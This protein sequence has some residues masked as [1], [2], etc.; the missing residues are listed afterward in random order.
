MPGSNIPWVRLEK[1]GSVTIEVEV[2]DAAGRDIVLLHV[3]LTGTGDPPDSAGLAIDCL[4]PGN[5]VVTRVG[6]TFTIENATA[7]SGAFAEG[8]ALVSAIVALSPKPADSSQWG[9]TLR[10]KTGEKR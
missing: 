5:T 1:D 7:A 8:M 10:L 3:W 6:D 2:K 9:R 4:N